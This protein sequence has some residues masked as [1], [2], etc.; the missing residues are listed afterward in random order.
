MTGSYDI[1]LVI[2]SFV[3]AS[4]ASYV[5]LNLAARV[6]ASTTIKSKGFWLVSGSLSMGTG[7]WSMHFIGMLAYRL[8]IPMSYDIPITLLSMLIAVLVSG[9]A[10]F[11]VSQ[12][13]L[14]LRRLLG[15]GTLMG[16]GIVA[17]HYTGMT[18]MKMLPPIRYD[19][20][21]F[22][23]SVSIAIVASTVAL[24]IA[25]QLREHA[26]LSALWKKFGAALVMGAAI[27]GM[28]YTGM[29]AAIIVPGSICTVTPGFINNGWLAGMIGGLSIMFLA[30]TL[31][32]SVFDERIADRARKLAETLHLANALESRTSELSRSN[33]LL[34]RHVGCLELIASGVP[35]YE[36]LKEITQ[37]V[38][39][40][41]PDMLC[42]ILLIDEAGTHFERATAP[43]LPQEFSAAINGAA[44]FLKERVVV[45]DIEADPKWAEFRELARRFNL[46]ACWFN[47]IMS[48]DAKRLGT[49]A[50]YYRE[51]REPNEREL[52]VIK[53]ASSLAGIVIERARAEEQMRASLAEKE[54]LLKEIH[55]RVKNNMQVISSMLNLQ[56]GRIQNPRTR[57]MFRDA[58]NRIKSMGLIHER[59]YQQHTLARVEF[60]DYLRQLVGHLLRSYRTGAVT[61]DLKADDVSLDIDSAVP[62]GLIVN[63]LV[64]N[65]LKHAFANGRAGVL[66]VTLR[67][68]DA[69][70][71]DDRARLMIADDGPGIPAGFDLRT[72]TSL[73]LQLVVDLTEQIGGSIEWKSANGARWTLSVPTVNPRQRTR[74]TS[75]NPAA[76]PDQ[77]PAD[78]DISPPAARAQATGTG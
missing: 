25:F 38:E 28:H 73:G 69:G 22:M 56:M 52:Q 2:L 44:A 66:T 11:I 55:H 7:I 19:P 47:P 21:F 27:C 23:L 40:E 57:E 48:S 18:A 45:R 49:F 1:W 20:L 74:E 72:A 17:M 64:T 62:C 36:T 29:A 65:A 51:P 42:A 39:Y 68:A 59:L 41:F 24:L 15:A 9:F 63:E 60:A 54:V 31:L 30:T 50:S 33:T 16:F 14:E 53:V 10:L 4:I 37:L 76:P 58:Q 6:V 13:T 12:G 75:S 78:T 43:S 71:E 8:P 3:V 61:L 32:V 46:R 67:A 26:S 77:S 35:L 34:E 70:A 5:T